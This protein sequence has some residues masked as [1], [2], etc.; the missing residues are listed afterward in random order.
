[1]TDS[2]TDRTISK[3][4]EAADVAMGE[5]TAPDKLARARGPRSLSRPTDSRPPRRGVRARMCV[6]ARARAGN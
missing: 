4:I 6:C 5:L 1:M 3:A 2:Y